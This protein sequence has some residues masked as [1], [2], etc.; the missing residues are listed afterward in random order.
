MFRDLKTEIV[1]EKYMTLNLRL[2]ARESNG[3]SPDT[4]A[5]WRGDARSFLGPDGRALQ[6]FAAVF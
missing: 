1:G 5:L 4:Q 2:Q 3:E 6:D